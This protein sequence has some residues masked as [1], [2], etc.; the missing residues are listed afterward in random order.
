MTVPGARTS[1]YGN[2]A[3]DLSGCDE[4]HSFSGDVQKACGDRECQDS[5]RF[6]AAFLGYTA[7]HRQGKRT[8][9]A[10]HGGTMKH[11]LWSLSALTLLVGCTD[12]AQVVT[13]PSDASLQAGNRQLPGYVSTPAGWFHKSCV[14]EIPAGAR[15]SIDHVVT[16]RD[17]T[18]YQIPH[19][20]YPAY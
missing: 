5:Y 8:G 9:R 17:G 1:N 12:R 14:H 2:E 15:V 6:R 10:P 16:R 19:C 11:A 4:S 20:R 18:K 3:Y 7:N 13:A